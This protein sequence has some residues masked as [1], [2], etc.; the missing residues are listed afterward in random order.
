M[1]IQLAA[2]LICSA[3]LA[4]CAVQPVYSVPDQPITAGKSLKHDQVRAAI[5]RGAARYGWKVRDEGPNTVVATI[6]LRTHHAEVTIKYDARH[7]SI[8]YKNSNNLNYD[9]TNIHHA[10]NGWVHNLQS[11]INAE[12]SAS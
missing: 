6:D 9:G 11:A 2:A 1:K 5:A 8:E 7:Y 10:Y 3:L 12:L 4:G